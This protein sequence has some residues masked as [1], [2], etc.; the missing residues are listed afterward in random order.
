MEMAG[1]EVALGESFILF[2]F[3]HFFVK[4]KHK[5]ISLGLLRVR[6]INIT[7]FHVHILSHW[8]VFRGNNLL[9]AV[10]CDNNAFFWNMSRRTCLRLFLRR[11]HSSEICPWWFAWFVF[12]FHHRF[13]CKQIM[14]HEHSSL[15]TKPFGVEGHVF[16]LLK[17]LVE[18]CK[19]FC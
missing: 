8:R 10:I 3:L 12:S 16:R 19:S 11:C 15:L 14:H 1:L 5:H 18:V 9:R 4:I 17:E 7:V 2:C 6:I 13:T